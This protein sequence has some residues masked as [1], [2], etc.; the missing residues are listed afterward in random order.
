[1]IRLFGIKNCDT[2]KKA[3]NWLEQ[4]RLEY[5]FHDFRA[6]G[7]DKEQLSQWSKKVGWEQLL[8]KR[9]TT[10][11]ALSH[12]EQQIS[13]EATALKLMYKQPTL[14]KR[15]VLMNNKKVLVGFKVDAYKEAL[16]SSC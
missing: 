3:R 9:S 14:I 6:D 16:L 12:K 5:N 2:V 15:P 11:R 1:M 13:D 7:L 8:N 4:N 10:F